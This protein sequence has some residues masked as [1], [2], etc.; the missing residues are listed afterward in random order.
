MNY[1]INIM[2]LLTKSFSTFVVNKLQFCPLINI[3]FL[4]FS[5]SF[6]ALS[7]IALLA[8]WVLGLLK[9]KKRVAV[10]KGLTVKNLEANYLHYSLHLWTTRG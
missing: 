7:S 8:L 2:H 9:A 10:K 1:L 3:A 4:G 6:G 5:I